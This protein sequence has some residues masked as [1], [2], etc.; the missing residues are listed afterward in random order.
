MERGGYTGVGYFKV[1]YSKVR[2][3]CHVINAADVVS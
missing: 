3:V 2:R 1:A